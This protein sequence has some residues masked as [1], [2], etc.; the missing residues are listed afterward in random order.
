VKVINDLSILVQLNKSNEAQVFLHGFPDTKE[1]WLP[2]L[3]RLSGKNFIVPDLP[4]F[5]SSKIVDDAHMEMSLIADQIVDSI[6]TL[7]IDC[8]SLVGHDWGGF[9]AWEIYSKA[10][11]RVSSITLTNATHPKVYSE[12]LKTSALQ[13]QI[14]KYASF[15]T[16]VGAPARLMADQAKALKLYHPFFVEEGPGSRL[17]F[18]EKWRDSERLNAALGIYRAN[19]ENIVQGKVP[20]VKAK[21]PVKVFWGT[22]DHSLVVENAVG[23]EAHCLA[24]YSYKFVEGGHWAFVEQADAFCRFLE[25]T[26]VE[27]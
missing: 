7:G 25:S 2:V 10:P 22:S 3:D 17:F 14:G 4:S 8:F 23:L 9:I 21:V 24:G 13:R 26:H 18:E 19:L 11:Q 27:S 1:V 15:F 5:G 6:S 16:S 12:L 20:L